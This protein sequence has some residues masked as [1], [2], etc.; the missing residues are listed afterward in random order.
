MARWAKPVMVSFWLLSV[1]SVTLAG[2]HH[3]SCFQLISPQA[4]PSLPK[5][6]NVM[7]ANDLVLLAYDSNTGRLAP[8]NGY[9]PDDQESQKF[10]SEIR[11][12]YLAWDPWVETEYQALVREVNASSP[13]A[14]SYYMQVLKACELDDATGAVRAVTRYSLNGEDVLQYPADQNRWFSV[15]PAAWR[16]VESWNRK[17][18]TST[19]MNVRT[20]QQCRIFIGITAP[21]TA[22]K[23]G[24]QDRPRRLICHVTGFYPCDIEVAWERGGQVAQGEQLTS[25][26]RPNGDPTFPIQ[27]AEPA[28]L[29]DA[30]GTIPLPQAGHTVEP[31]SVCS[32]AGWGKTNRY[33]T[34]SILH[35]VELEVMPDETCQEDQ[36]LRRYYKPSKMMCGGDPAEDKA[37]FLVNAQSLGG[38]WAG[39]F[40]RRPR[41][42]GDQLG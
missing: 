29:N 7:K 8:R 39:S 13:Q 35:E 36:Q 28:E 9:S 42:L 24:I 4:A 6:L 2:V 31:G 21:F 38:G 34:T 14:E 20:L 12:W 37:W 5:R 32:V 1:C 30:V 16:V 40:P 17:G 18:E 33:T 27:L 26:I 15:H 25:G 19:V 41:E 23:T 22:Q 11:A 3:L 10:W